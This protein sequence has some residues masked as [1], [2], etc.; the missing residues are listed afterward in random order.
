M[1]SGRLPKHG[2]AGG[3]GKS[4]SPTY[5]SWQS[6]LKRCFKQNRPDYRIYGGRGITVYSEW[7]QFES[8][9]RDMGEK[10]PGL[11]L[12]RINNEGNY[13]PSNCRWETREEQNNNTRRN[14][15]ITI[16]GETKTVA[17]WARHRGMSVFVIHARL[18]RGESDY[19]AVMKPQ[20]KSPARLAK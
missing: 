4:V 6:M 9:L 19:D 2:H 15:L 17:G 13:E 10:P 14:R 20:R 11:S 7:L 16:D 18:H 8:F 1:P 5:H 12:G 3:R